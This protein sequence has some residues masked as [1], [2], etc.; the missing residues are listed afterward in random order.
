M[1]KNQLIAFF[2]FWTACACFGLL[3]GF[4]LAWLI[5]GNGNWPIA[6]LGAAGWAWAIVYLDKMSSLWLKRNS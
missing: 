3:A 4:A 1:S 6:A 5:I 2:P